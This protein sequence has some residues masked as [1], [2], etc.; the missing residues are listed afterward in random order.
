MALRHIFRLGSR[1]RRPQWPIDPLHTPTNLNGPPL[2]VIV[3]CH[4]MAAQ[5]NHT[6]Y[7]LLPPYQQQVEKDQYDVVLIDNG[8]AHPLPTSIWHQSD[9]VRYHHVPR[10]KA[11]RNPGVAVNWAV[12]ANRSPMLCIMIDGANLLTPGVMRWGIDLASLSQQTIVEVRNWQLGPKPQ[13]Q[14]ALEGYDTGAERALMHKT[15]W[16]DDPYRLFEIAAPSPA[17]PRAF[18]GS[19]VECTCLFMSR[20][21]FDKI[22]GFDERYTEPGGGLCNADF[23]HRAAKASNR[24]FTVLG[25][26]A[27]HQIHQ[28]PPP[29]GTS[30]EPAISK[31]LRCKKE[32]EK[33]SRPLRIP[34]DDYQSVLAGHVPPQSRRWL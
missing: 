20:A 21:L 19:A 22:G 28:A 32:Y 23:F 6:L 14:S 29:P 13:I 27:F 24:I 2:S 1:L 5:V 16:P 4:E 7:S 26:G 33:W 12:A 25:E 15:D 18:F 11:S 17:N 31:F 34:P 30:G 8:S 9:N 10:S 3:I